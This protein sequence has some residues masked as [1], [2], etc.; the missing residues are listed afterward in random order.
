M[1]THYI[2]TQI[3]PFAEVKS[4]QENARSSNK[5]TSEEA[6]LQNDEHK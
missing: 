4:I 5:A 2:H 6:I 1:A 3:I